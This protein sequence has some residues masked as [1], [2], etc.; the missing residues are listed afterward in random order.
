M[1]EMVD[2]SGDLQY[3]PHKWYTMT[4]YGFGKFAAEFFTIAFTTYCFFFYERVVGLSSWWTAFGYI[5]YAIWNA[6]NDP[7]I[8]YL[9][10]KP[11]KGKLGNKLG[12]RFP[13]ILMGAIPWV[14]IYLI[15]F[16]PPNLDPN[17]YG[18]VL[19]LWLT[20]W[21]CVF[22]T[23]Y[24]LWD[25]QYQAIFPDKFRGEQ[26][27]RK[28]AG[29]ATAVGIVG[30]ALGAL[31][32]PMFLKENVLREYFNQGAAVAVIGFIAVL[33][34]LPGVKEDRFMRAKYEQSMKYEQEQ[35]ST[36]F[37]KDMLYALKNRNLM[38]FLLLYFLYQSLAQSMTGSIPYFVEYVLE[39]PQTSV[40]FVMAGFLVGA[41]VSIPFWIRLA[42][43][44]RNN[45]KMILIGGFL[46]ALVTVPFIFVNQWRTIT[47]FGFSISGYNIFLWMVLWG[48]CLGL[49][50]SLTGPVMAD[51]ID[52][53]V[54]QT[55]V[56]KEGTY[57]GLRAFF[58]RLAFAVQALSF[59][60]VHQV[61][62]FI[63]GQPLIAQPDS[64]II[65]IHVHIAIIP[66]ILMLLGTII[67][68]ILNDLNPEK[69]TE[70]KLRLVELGL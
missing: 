41:L 11:P 49:F 15:I 24:S 65:G 53:I 36:S 1:T 32:P 57:M 19:F 50:W 3:R 26:E 48:S 62:G 51:V 69:N 31:I 10:N 63:E 47:I 14:F 42:N 17:Q 45:Q 58:G 6:I 22:D 43:K 67:F 70:I 5:I 38:A 18:W 29:I 46:L 28:A 34:L 4:S 39:E 25:V 7:L 13:Y 8:G 27:R 68:W 60:I 2:R 55:R 66:I 21:A 16:T 44:L 59:A 52:E 9:T 33:F 20:I 37:F 56:R 35:G 54:V 61:T 23:L 30:I 12:R 40:T 64:A